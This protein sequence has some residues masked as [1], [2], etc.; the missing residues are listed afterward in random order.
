MFF[1]KNSFFYKLNQLIDII[2]RDF[3][4]KKLRFQITYV[5]KSVKYFTK[6]FISFFVIDTLPIIS[7]LCFY[8]NAN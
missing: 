1:L 4:D 6:L 7:I 2:V 8:K 3:L 5:V